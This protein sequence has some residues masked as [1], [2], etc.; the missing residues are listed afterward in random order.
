[1]LVAGDIRI[2][3]KKSLSS[4]GKIISYELYL[5]KRQLCESLK[6]IT[7]PGLKH[8]LSE[9]SISKLRAI[10]RLGVS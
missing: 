5:V 10:G 6:G 2:N 7:S 1:M 4:M 8:N 3:M 9:R